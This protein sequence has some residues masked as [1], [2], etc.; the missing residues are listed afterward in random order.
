MLAAQH[1]WGLPRSQYCSFAVEELTVALPSGVLAVPVL[2]DD[3]VI[4][5]DPIYPHVGLDVPVLQSGPGLVWC[6]LQASGVARGE[7]L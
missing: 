1:G 3:T 7:L 6:A 5:L 4:C 2:S